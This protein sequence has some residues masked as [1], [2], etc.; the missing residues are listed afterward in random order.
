VI[1]GSEC[2][3]QVVKILTAS[4]HSRS[5]ADSQTEREI[6]FDELA[7]IDRSQQILLKGE[8]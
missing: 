2:W 1:A 4:S 5:H 7:G 8:A 3:S 6:N